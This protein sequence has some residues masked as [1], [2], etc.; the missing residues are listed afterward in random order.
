[1]LALTHPIKPVI[2]IVF[3]PVSD[4]KASIEWY[5]D[6]FEQPIRPEKTGGGIYWGVIVR[7][8]RNHSRQQ[9]VGLPA[10]DHVRVSPGYRRF[11]RL[12]HCNGLFA[13]RRAVSLFRRRAF[14]R[15]REHG[16]LGRVARAAAGAYGRCTPVTHKDQPRYCAWRPCSRDGELVCRI[17]AKRRPAGSEVQGLNGIAMDKGADLL[18]DDNRL[19]QSG[20]VYY[21]KLQLDLRV[22]PALMIDSPDV[23]AARAHVIAKG[24]TDVTGIEERM[25]AECFTFYDPYGNGIMV[26]QTR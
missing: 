24:A 21:E 26:R 25:G 18:V 8:Y 16:L 10:D 19:S 20:K 12:L 2:N 3:L 1:M 15:W 9:Y 13:C 7:R 14:R 17:F 6:L 4:L 11:V 5:A 22:A 23:E